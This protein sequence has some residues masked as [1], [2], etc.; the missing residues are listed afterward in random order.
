[1]VTWHLQLHCAL[2]THY[3]PLLFFTHFC[4]PSIVSLPAAVQQVPA[5]LQRY[6]AAWRC[7]TE[8]Q[9]WRPSLLD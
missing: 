4:S 2:L 6:G 8:M 7:D 1:M 5:C 3:H 9:P